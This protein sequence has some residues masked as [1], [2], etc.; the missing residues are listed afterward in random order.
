[1][2]ADVNLMI[3]SGNPAE[4]NRFPT[5]DPCP[6][7]ADHKLLY[8]FS[9]QRTNC[10]VTPN[11]P[12]KRAQP[13]DATNS[14]PFARRFPGEPQEYPGIHSHGMARRARLDTIA[15]VRLLRQRTLRRLVDLDALRHMISRWRLCQHASSPLAQRLEGVPPL[16][17][18]IF[19]LPPPQDLSSASSCESSPDS[20]LIQP[21]LPLM[22]Q[23]CALQIVAAADTASLFAATI[24]AL[25]VI[26]IQQALINWE[27]NLTSDW[28]SLHLLRDQGMRIQEGRVTAALS[29]GCKL[30]DLNTTSKESLTDI[31]TPRILGDSS[32]RFSGTEQ[33]HATSSQAEQTT[34]GYYDHCGLTGLV[35]E[36][37]NE[38]TNILTSQILRNSDFESLDYAHWDMNPHFAYNCMFN[39][40]ISSTTNLDT[41]FWKV[42]RSPRAYFLSPAEEYWQQQQETLTG[43]AHSFQLKDRRC[44]GSPMN[45]DTNTSSNSKCCTGRNDFNGFQEFRWEFDQ[46]KVKQLRKQKRML[47]L[48]QNQT[49]IPVTPRQHGKVSTRHRRS[50]C[51]KQRTPRKAPPLGSTIRSIE[52]FRN[53]LV[54]QLAKSAATRLSNK[55]FW[56]HFQKPPNDAI[57]LHEP[58]RPPPPPYIIWHLPDGLA[59]MRELQE[60]EPPG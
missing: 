51:E 47:W 33:V 1:M 9:P 44:S 18:A 26:H 32:L 40:I 57:D 11:V 42:S 48:Q 23:A 43:V 14:N 37:V 3:A 20:F 2:E 35:T 19:L 49:C 27:R 41:S 50:S 17:S 13:S 30:A 46:G 60:S 58:L 21:R 6:Y 56:I 22:D 29:D 5:S 7:P 24:P 4:H 16:S 28:I 36:P 31:L 38:L 8:P 10:H 25:R 12:A 15:W 52:G 34:A 39:C 55:I 59:L 45:C 54:K 53:R